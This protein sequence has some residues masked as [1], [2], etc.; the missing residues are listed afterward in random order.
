MKCI[1]RNK[2][3]ALVWAVI[4]VS[5]LFLTVAGIL[6]VC[7]SYFNRT[8]VDYERENAFL[9]VRSAAEFI[10][11]DISTDDDYETHSDYKPGKYEKKENIKV[12]FDIDNTGNPAFESKVSVVRNDTKIRIH[13]VCEYPGGTASVGAV[14]TCEYKIKQISK[15]E[16]VTIE[17]WKL[18]GFTDI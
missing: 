8:L 3:A 17:E 14:M 16:S 15:D 7:L 2:G 12:S 1:F 13:A 9:A 4:V 18:D 10:A 5:I 11:Y 6:T